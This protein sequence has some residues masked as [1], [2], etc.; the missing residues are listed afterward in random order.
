MRI[1]KVDTDSSKIPGVTLCMS[2]ANF[3]N[4]RHS[5]MSKRSNKVPYVEKDYCKP[6]YFRERFIFETFASRKITR[7]QV[8]A[9]MSKLYLFL[10]YYIK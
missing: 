3:Y 7:I 5:K 1:L 9:N 2:D 8:N 10:F 6:T 4:G